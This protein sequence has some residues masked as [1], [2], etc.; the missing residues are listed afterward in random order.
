VTTRVANTT[1]DTITSVSPNTIVRNHRNGR[2]SRVSYTRCRARW[3]AAT[4]FEAEMSA[5][6]VP[7]R[8]A[9]S[10]PPVRAIDR[11]T[12]SYGCGSTDGKISL[13]RSPRV[14]TVC[15]SMPIRLTSET[16]AMAA[17]STDSSV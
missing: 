1:I 13:T 8:N 4:P 17:G 11:I 12:R 5:P 6:I 10:P 3:K 9:V 7:S 15:C 2:P 16:I 14:S